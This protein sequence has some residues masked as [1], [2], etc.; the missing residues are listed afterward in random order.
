MSYAGCLVDLY[1]NAESIESQSLHPIETSPALAPTV[2]AGA[3]AT[4]LDAGNSRQVSG[5]KAWEATPPRQSLL[6]G[7]RVTS[8][9]I[10]TIRSRPGSL[11]TKLG[12]S[13]LAK[14]WVPIAV[15]I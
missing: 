4:L 11:N 7:R 9:R 13:T 10:E 5:T 2:L 12:G 8:R 3:R 6:W 15:G 14:V 1:L